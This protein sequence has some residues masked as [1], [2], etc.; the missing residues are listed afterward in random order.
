M[1]QTVRHTGI[2]VTSM[3]RSLEFYRDWLGLRVVLDKA[4]S[5]ELIDKV[6]ALPKVRMR[7]VM[8]EAPDGN[9]IELFEFYSHPE[10]APEEV[11]T[12]TIGCSHVAFCVDDL[13]RLHEELSRK[14][15]KFNCEPQVSPDGYAKLTYCHDPDGTILELVQ[16]L[17][18]SKVPYER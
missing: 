14:G 7:I 11:R 6:T 10:R 9:R 15:I 3:E 17:D 12:C 16:I 18:E 8:L 1:I 13:D 4:Q 5:G 2:V